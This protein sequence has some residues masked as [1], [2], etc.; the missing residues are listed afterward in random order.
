MKPGTSIIFRTKG[1]GAQ[2][3]AKV[4]DTIIKDGNTA[5][6]ATE[7]KTGELLIISPDEIDVIEHE[8]N[9]NP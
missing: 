6:L 9:Q 1:K 2:R 5:Y 7:N 4:E 8:H 3:H